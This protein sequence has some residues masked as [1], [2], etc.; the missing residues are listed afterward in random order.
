MVL[1]CLKCKVEFKANI[2]LVFHMFLQYFYSV[3]FQCV[4]PPL[5]MTYDFH[6]KECQSESYKSRFILFHYIKIASFVSGF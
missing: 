2:K 5:S 3:N 4:Y 6:F 1:T